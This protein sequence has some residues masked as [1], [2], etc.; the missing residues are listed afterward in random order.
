DPDVAFELGKSISKT[1]AEIANETRVTRRRRTRGV[2]IKDTPRV[3]K[4]KSADH[5]QK[6]KG[7]EVMTVKEQLAAD[8]MQALKAIKKLSWIQSHTRCSSQ[9][10]GIILEVPDESTVIVATLS[11]GTGTIPG[12]LD[13]VKRASEAKADPVINW[14]SEKESDYSTDSDELK[15]VEKEKIDEK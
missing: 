12:V 3:S 8:M 2:T 14:G 5:S 15:G 1:N 13:K 10:T 7:I 11:E 9:G 4:K 6:L